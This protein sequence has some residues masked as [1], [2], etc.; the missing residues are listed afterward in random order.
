MMIYNFDRQNNYFSI[1]SQFHVILITLQ[2][3]IFRIIC[4]LK[5]VT[6]IRGNE[7][8]AYRGFCRII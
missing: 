8:M 2:K 3:T 6:I 4:L 5:T 7:K 1:I